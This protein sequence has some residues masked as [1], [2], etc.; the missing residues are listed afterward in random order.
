MCSFKLTQSRFPVS[1]NIGFDSNVPRR[2]EFGCIGLSQVE[3]ILV[4]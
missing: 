4:V 3:Y 2:I 1:L